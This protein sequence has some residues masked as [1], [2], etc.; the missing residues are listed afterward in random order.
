MKPVTLEGGRVRL[1]PMSLE[2]AAGLAAVGLDPELWR[3]TA[4]NIANRGSTRFANFDAP[5][6]RVKRRLQE[7]LAR[8]G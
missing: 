7:R 3:I 1:E 4:T 5:S 2:H 8:H 6:L